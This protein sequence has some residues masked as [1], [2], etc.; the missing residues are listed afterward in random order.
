MAACSVSCCDES[1]GVII[2]YH[3]DEA[4]DSGGTYRYLI[5]GKVSRRLDSSPTVIFLVFVLNK[6][7]ST[8]FVS[9]HAVIQHR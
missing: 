1:T 3:E 2:V 4:V 8:S 6:F 7:S 5:R 9:R